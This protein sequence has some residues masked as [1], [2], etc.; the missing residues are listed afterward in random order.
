MCKKIKKIKKY[1]FS[2][3]IIGWSE[4]IPS[5]WVVP[6]TSENVLLEA[7][8]ATT[9]PSPTKIS[10]RENL[11]PRKSG[12]SKLLEL[13]KRIFGFS[14][15]RGSTMKASNRAFSDVSDTSQTLGMFSDH[16]MIKFEK[17][18]F[19][20]FLKFFTHFW[21]DLDRFWS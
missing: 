2:K 8:I 9:P 6:E 21:M 20:S 19:L 16:P 17:T 15:G 10:F 14:W 7:F 11:F 5:H 3:F 1:V 18:Y 13:V 12:F 4:N